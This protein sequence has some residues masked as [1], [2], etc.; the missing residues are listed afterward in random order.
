M[1][2]VQ[3][4]IEANANNTSVAVNILLR[5]DANPREA[6]LAKAIY[7]FT[8]KIL[9]TAAKKAGFDKVIVV[10]EDVEKF[11]K[12]HHNTQNEGAE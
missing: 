2:Q 9:I 10:D 7:N 8:T 1:I 3:T 12:D 6:K 4:T 11:V 5:E